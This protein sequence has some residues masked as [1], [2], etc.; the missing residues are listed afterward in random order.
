MRVGQMNPNSWNS[1]TQISTILF[2]F[3]RAT[4]ECEPTKEGMSASTTP[5]AGC[6]LLA[7]QTLALRSQH[8]AH[9][10]NEHRRDFDF[11]SLDPKTC[12]FSLCNI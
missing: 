8:Q 9:L 6:D 1:G 12:V 3:I 5:D 11:L 10:G 7:S 4:G 2:S